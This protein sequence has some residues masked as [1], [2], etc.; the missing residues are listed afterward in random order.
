MRERAGLEDV[1][2]KARYTVLAGHRRIE[3]AI[4]RTDPV[5]DVA[6]HRAGCRAHWCL[7][8]PCN[9]G[10]RPLSPAQN[11]QRLRR[12]Q[13]IVQR[14]GWRALPA[15]NCAADGRWLEPGLC[16]L[17]V[18]PRAVQQLARRY[19]QSAWVLGR[20]GSPPRLVWTR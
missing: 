10:S 9:P 14:R 4:G 1:Y 2:R 12:L 3:F 16:L 6:M 17:D 5:A 18:V 20:L 7:L 8:T 15:V 13:Q 19:D 11:A